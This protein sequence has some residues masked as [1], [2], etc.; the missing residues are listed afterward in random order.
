MLTRIEGLLNP[1]EL[2]QV[3]RFLDAAAF[4]SGTASAGESAAAVKN[5]EELPPGA[6]ETE[7][8]NRIVMGRLVEH[9]VYRSAALPLKVATPFYSRYRE[10]MAYGPHVDDPVMG[11][12]PR[13][14][15]D[16]AVTV[17]LNAPNEYEG[18]A[19]CI[20]TEFGEQ[21]VKLDAGS[22]VLYPASSLHRV[23]TVTAGVRFAAVTWIQSLVRDASRRHLLY[24]LAQARDSLSGREADERASILVDQVYVNL[25]RMWSDT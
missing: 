1:P 5:N 10:G 17:F 21:S 14:R 11:Q 8:L 25:V 2:R 19:L 7:P 22:A 6:S 9:P 20:E 4:V 15:S 18:G 24:Q 13:Y 12:G 3:R 23:E 16:I